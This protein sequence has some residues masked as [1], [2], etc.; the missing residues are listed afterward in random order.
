MM[1]HIEA[2]TP[3]GWDGGGNWTDELV[4][5]G[6]KKG[7]NRQCSIGYHEECSDPSGDE[8]RCHCHPWA[9]LGDPQ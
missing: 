2:P 5:R 8:C 3:P 9:S 7:I 6:E 1:I 4:R